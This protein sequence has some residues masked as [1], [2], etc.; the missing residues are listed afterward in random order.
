M[1]HSLLLG[2][3]GTETEPYLS[4]ALL[5]KAGATVW[6]PREW[7]AEAGGVRGR[8]WAATK[9]AHL[10]CQSLNLVPEEQRRGFTLDDK[11]GGERPALPGRSVSNGLALR[12]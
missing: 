6:G 7:E 12:Y 11:R 9:F 4:P 8:G 5:L 10:A 2:T 3:G 1:P